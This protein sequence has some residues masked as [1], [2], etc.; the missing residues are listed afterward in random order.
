MAAKFLEFAAGLA[1]DH[2]EERARLAPDLGRSL[3]GIGELRRAEEV[4][5][6][7]AAET[8]EAP[9][10]FAFLERAS[11]RDY[12]EANGDSFKELEAAP[13]RARDSAPDVAARAGILDAEISWTKGA[14]DAME[15][16]LDTASGAAGRVK[17]TEKRRS[18]FNAIQGWQARGMLL[19]PERADIGL[20][21]CKE[22]VKGARA[23]GSR[24]LEASL[25]AVCAGLHAM[26]DEFDEARDL[27]KES[28]RIGE[29]VGLTAWLG[30]LALYSGPVE[31]LAG[32]PADAARQLRRGLAALERMGDRSRGAT[33]AAYLAHAQYEAGELGEAEVSALGSEDLAAEEDVFTQVVWRGALAKIL[34]HKDCDRAV[35]LAEEAVARSDKTSSPNLRGDARLDLAKVLRECGDPENARAQADEARGRY[36]EKGN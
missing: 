27:Y 23:D 9:A 22:M 36:E 12:T 18:L 2:E 32:K 14:Y 11:L 20:T 5:G 3:E 4:L 17:D 1:R 28:R 34:A 24:A 33:A 8:G 15:G 21:R 35:P 29:A 26:Q 31:L 19:G 6:E 30:A 7:A 10:R 16:Q 13:D 25:L